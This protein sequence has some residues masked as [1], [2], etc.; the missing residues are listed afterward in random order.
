MIMGLS[1][2]KLGLKDLASSFYTTVANVLYIKILTRW[3]N[4]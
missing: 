3:E 1:G 4:F 2:K